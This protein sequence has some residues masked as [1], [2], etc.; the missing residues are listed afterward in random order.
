MK[1]ES[2][3]AT[4]Y[5]EQD[6]VR[7]I[8]K[9][10]KTRE[11]YFLKNYKSPYFVKLIREIPNGIEMEY[12]GKSMG[13]NNRNYE[14]EYIFDRKM[15][16]KTGKKRVIRW[17]QELREELKRLNISHRDISP[18]NIL[19]KENGDELRL[20]DFTW[21]VEGLWDE[22]ETDRWQAPYPDNKYID[23]L[24]KQLC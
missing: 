16:L 22:E 6:V 11:A 21:A 9:I 20:I 18:A 14:G 1:I 10:K 12:A 8:Y 17:L 2:N 15:I 13:I 7:K 5:I 19:Y 4:I 23:I 24:L 3:E